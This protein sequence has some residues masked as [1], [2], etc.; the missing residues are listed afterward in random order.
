[1]SKRLQLK[2]CSQVFDTLEKL[3]AHI[4]NN[5]I[6]T[7]RR[8][9]EK[10]S[11]FISPLSERISSPSVVETHTPSAFMSEPPSRNMSQPP[12]NM[13]NPKPKSKPKPYLC[14]VPGC[15]RSYDTFKGLGNHTLAK[16]TD[17]TNL[18]Y[19]C[20][21]EGCPKQYASA[22]SLRKHTKAQ[23][24][25]ERGI[26][27][28]VKVEASLEATSAEKVKCGR[29]F[30]T[31]RGLRLHHGNVHGLWKCGQPK[32]NFMGESQV[33]LMQHRLV[34]GSDEGG[35]RYSDTS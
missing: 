23:H 6:N 14:P 2:C 9:E 8:M 1:M 11:L 31:T 33:E 35:G 7:S 12:S 21:V 26:T 25:S 10:S 16:H 15:Y 27:C 13:S 18:R 5:H 30:A 28:E 32:C 24:S 4:C 34:S 20:A 29:L 3:E 17:R 19:K 22:D